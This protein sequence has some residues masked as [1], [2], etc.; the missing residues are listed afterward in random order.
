MFFRDPERFF[1]VF[2]KQV[3][4]ISLDQDSRPAGQCVSVPDEQSTRQTPAESKLMQRALQNTLET[5]NC[6]NELNSP[7]FTRS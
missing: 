4:T 5:E 1:F 7:L 2:G 3:V 6:I